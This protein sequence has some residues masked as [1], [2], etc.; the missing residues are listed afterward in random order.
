MQA[1]LL[2]SVRLLLVTANVLPSSPI[3]VTLMM[4]AL[5]SSETSI[6]TRSKRHNIPEY[7]ILYSHRRENLKS[8]TTKCFN[9]VCE[10]AQSYKLD[11]SYKSLWT[12]KCTQAYLR[13]VRFRGQL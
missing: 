8:Y 1:S 3:L 2:R 5:R 10:Y 7:A 4:Q 9:T 6:L 11:V 13:H 12:T